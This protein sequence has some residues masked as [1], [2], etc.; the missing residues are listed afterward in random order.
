MRIT[1]PSRRERK[2]RRVLL[3][4]EGAAPLG[5]VDEDSCGEEEN[6]PGERQ[7]SGRASYR[8]EERAT[9]RSVPKEYASSSKKSLSRRE[10]SEGRVKA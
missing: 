5:E 10:E 9:K 7:R 8:E 1:L 6:A 2:K 4:E 3:T